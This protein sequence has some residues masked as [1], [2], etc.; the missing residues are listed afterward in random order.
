MNPTFDS[1]MKAM[2]F[3]R[4]TCKDCKLHSPSVAYPMVRCNLFGEYVAPTF[5][6]EE[7]KGSKAA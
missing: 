3:N 1:M 7:F 6:C 5:V 4:C 2:G